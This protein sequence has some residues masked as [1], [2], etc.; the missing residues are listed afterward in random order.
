MKQYSETMRGN[1][2]DATATRVQLDILVLALLTVC[3]FCMQMDRGNIGN[4]VTDDLFADINIKQHQYNVGQQL[5]YL[6]IVL[7]EIPSNIILYRVGPRWW[8]S[9]QII[10]WGAVEIGQYAMHNVGSFYA[11]RILL[12]LCEAGF[13]PAALYTL[14]MWY[15][16]AET[17]KRFAIFYFGNLVSQGGTSLL[18][19]GIFQLG[20]RRGLTGWQWMFIIEGSFT[21]FMGLMLLLFLP[22]DPSDPYPLSR[23]SYFSA[24][25]REIVWK[26]VVYDDPSKEKKEKHVTM[27]Q[28]GKTVRSKLHRHVCR[29]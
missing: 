7:L 28:L 24:R 15:K 3:F 21:I 12:G 23:L 18:A 16:R 6:G 1:P 8:L 19:Y 26:R 9:G 25:E 20:G 4:A 29:N 22:K 2:T 5:L 27:A 11:T 13:I 17:S 14:S 10:A